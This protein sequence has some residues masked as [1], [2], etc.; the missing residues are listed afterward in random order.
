MGLFRFAQ[1]GT[2]GD[3]A[4]FW[5]RAR[6]SRRMSSPTDMI[7]A[8]SRKPPGR[9]KIRRGTSNRRMADPALFALADPTRFAGLRLPRGFEERHS[10]SEALSHGVA[11]R[12]QSRLS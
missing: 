3:H 4:G 12:R 8:A 2:V 10:L 5:P 11:L 7:L 6:S 9:R 1:S